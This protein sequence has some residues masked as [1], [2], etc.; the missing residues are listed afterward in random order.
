MNNKSISSGQSDAKVQLVPYSPAW[1]V[2]FESE[3]LLLKDAIAPWLAGPIEHVGSTAVPA[4][5]A[6]PITDI[7]APVRTLEDSRAAIDAVTEV[8]YVYYPYKPEVMHW[9]CKP[10]PSYR[11]HHLHL[12]PYES[13]LW[14][15]RLAFRNALRETTALAKEYGE[16]KKCLATKFSQDR[17]AYTQ[18]KAPFIRRVLWATKVVK[19]L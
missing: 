8:G 7:M 3:R 14:F 5:T 19:G 10:A 16:L 18:A 13:E 12:V 15:E 11:T 9:F 17:E 1:P 4:L 2:Q 6:K